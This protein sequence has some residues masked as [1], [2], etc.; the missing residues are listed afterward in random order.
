MRRVQRRTHP[1]RSAQR[2][3]APARDSRSYREP[4]RQCWAPA[5]G[6]GPVSQPRTRACIFPLEPARDRRCDGCICR[7]HARSRATARPLTRSARENG[8]TARADGEPQ[9][10]LAAYASHHDNRRAHPPDRGIYL[11]AQA[12]P[13]TISRD[14]PSI[15]WPVRAVDAGERKWFCCSDHHIDSI[16]LQEIGD[17]DVDPNR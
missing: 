7:R 3:R 10:H 4:R 6:G 5:A 17:H 16:H 9:G 13:A 14:L 12:T 11:S 1:R 15:L 8:D 2:R